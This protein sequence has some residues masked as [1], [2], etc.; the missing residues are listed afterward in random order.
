MSQTRRG[1]RA[2][3]RGC[4]SPRKLMP[5][6]SALTGAPRGCHPRRARCGQGQACEEYGFEKGRVL[7]HHAHRARKGPVLIVG[8]APG[9]DFP[10]EIRVVR[11]HR[12]DGVFTGLQVRVQRLPACPGIRVTPG[13]RVEYVP[14][15]PFPAFVILKRHMPAPQ[16]MPVIKIDS[17]R[18]H[19]CMPQQ[20]NG[21]ARGLSA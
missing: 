21:Q 1:P 11:E 13:R 5:G 9:R 20:I 8:A 3:E 12:C 4:R 14:I 18:R 2:G 10:M 16:E 6:R 7:Q 17:P 19:A 15:Y